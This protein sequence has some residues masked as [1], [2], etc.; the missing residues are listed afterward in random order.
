MSWTTT[1]HRIALTVVD[2]GVSS[3]TTLGAL[4]LLAH[5]TDA[6]GFGALAIGLS[7]VV[8]ATGVA[9]SLGTDA[10]AVHHSDPTAPGWH[11]AAASA[12]G[13]AL[14]VGLI[15]GAMSIL[16]GVVAAET[17][18]GVLLV[19][20][21][22]LPVVC[23]ADGWRGVALAGRRPEAAIAVDGIWAVTFC[24]AAWWT[25]GSTLSPALLVVVWGCGAWFAAG[26]GVAIFRLAPSL[27]SAVAWLRRHGALARRC[28]TEFVLVA[29]SSQLVLWSIAVSRGFTEAGAM[30]AAALVLGLA[31]VVANGIIAAVVPESARHQEAARQLSRQ[32]AFAAAGMMLVWAMLVWAVPASVGSAVL[33]GRW[34]EARP[35]FLPLALL[36]AGLILA[37]VSAGGLRA[38]GR[39]DQSVRLLGALTFASVVAGVAVSPLG[40]VASCLAM[41]VP[42]WVGAFVSLRTLQS[43][44]PRRPFILSNGAS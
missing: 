21:A 11:D 10:L 9:R 19:I 27:W 20:G 12:M 38:L 4:V 5:R 42:V 30:R 29:G 37:I 16:V 6:S 23:L 32:L 13:S 44:S 25:T 33:E 7:V 18:G 31:G 8:I 36:N 26:L 2:Q 14:L 1:H 3:L 39:S 34:A 17:L 15:A 28:L 40:A 22:F 24:L 35:I 43:A 41:A